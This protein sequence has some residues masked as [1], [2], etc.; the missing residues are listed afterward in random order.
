MIH[1][2][3]IPR[4]ERT[5]RDFH[6]AFCA[7][8]R[9]TM[10]DETREAQTLA[11]KVGAEL[12]ICEIRPPSEGRLLEAISSCDGPMHAL[13]FY[14]IWELYGFI[15]KSGIEVTLDGQ[16][17]DEMMGGYYETIRSALRCALRSGRLNWLWDIYKIYSEQGETQ[18]YSSK[19]FA[20]HEL[21]Q[22]MKT[23][24]SRLKRFVLHH[25]EGRSHPQSHLEYAQPVPPNL[26]PLSVDLYRQFCQKQLPTILQQFDRCSMAHG[27]ESRMPFMDYRIVEFVF[28]LSEESIVGRGHTK[29]VLREAMKGLVPESTRLRKVK[30]GFNAPIVEWFLAPLQELMVDTMNST[31][32]QENPFFDGRG[33]FKRFERW[34]EAP[35]WG[36]AWAFWPPVHFVLWEN[37]LRASRPH[38]PSSFERTRNAYAS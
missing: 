26:N 14:P 33:L 22:L 16:G 3:I 9:N 38:A 24:L 13:A 10:L 35:N 32:F 37:Q 8:F 4:G 12:E 18:F 20:K 23:P 21:V 29:R 1:Q 7:A 30:L 27:V 19:R 17:P 34:L 6:R 11:D 36:D 15:K 25:V 5:A 2:G 28:S 31:Y